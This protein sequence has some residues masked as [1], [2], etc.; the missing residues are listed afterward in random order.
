MWIC[1]IFSKKMFESGIEFG[2]ENQNV[3]LRELVP[4][5]HVLINMF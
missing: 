3:M 1:S 2:K 4:L 5:G